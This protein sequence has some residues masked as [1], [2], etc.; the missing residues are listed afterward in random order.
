MSIIQDFLQL[1]VERIKN[2]EIKQQ[3]EDIIEKYKQAEDKEFF[4]SNLESVM[5][6]LYEMVQQ[7]SSEIIQEAAEENPCE[8]PVK[9]KPVTKKQGNAAKP[10]K[11]SKKKKTQKDKK[12][13]AKTTKEDILKMSPRLEKCNKELKAFHAARRK[14][15]PQKTPPTRYTKI[16]RHI[17]A[18]GKLIPPRLKENLQVQQETKKILMKAHRDILNNFKMTSLKNVK[19]DQT[20]IKENFQKIEEKLEE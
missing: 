19:R 16:K 14:S 4:V 1:D 2:P 9:E 13:S 11:P 7:D 8:D 6:T 17:L 18:L 15:L 5:Q 10:K 12:P 3:V 20:E